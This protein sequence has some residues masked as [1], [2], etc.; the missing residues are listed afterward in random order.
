MT[1]INERLGQLIKE[2]QLNNNSFAKAIRVNPVV[3]F[4]IIEGRKTKPSFDLLQKI[5]VTFDNINAAW[6]ITG[7]GSIFVSNSYAKNLNTKHI[8]DSDNSINSIIESQERLISAITD[9]LKTNNELNKEMLKHL[10]EK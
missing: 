10:S 1:T 2:L 3:T 6:L 9:H 7:K 8:N 4:N 5:L